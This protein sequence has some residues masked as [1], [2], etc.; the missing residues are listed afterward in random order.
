[1]TENRATWRK[2]VMEGCIEFEQKRVDHAA[3]TRALRKQ[4]EN[5]LTTNVVQD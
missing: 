1:M 4:E 5:E 3:L 2:L